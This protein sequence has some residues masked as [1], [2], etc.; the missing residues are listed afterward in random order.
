M[1]ALATQDLHIGHP[2][3]QRGARPTLMYRRTVS[4]GLLTM[5]MR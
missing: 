2:E 4:R 5:V 3:P 1:I